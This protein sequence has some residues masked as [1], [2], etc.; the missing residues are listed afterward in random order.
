[1]GGETKQSNLYESVPAEVRTAQAARILGV[2]KDTLLRLKDEGLL[3]YRNVAPPSSSRPIYAFTLRSVMELRTNYQVDVP[4]LP[5]RQVPR[6]QAVKGPRRYK[7]L[8]V[9]D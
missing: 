8:D 1:M 5:L 9:G 7:H 6:R 3:E 2:S 4:S